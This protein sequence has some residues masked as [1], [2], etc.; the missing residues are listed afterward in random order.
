[1]EAKM[2]AHTAALEARLRVELAQAAPV[3]GAITSAVA[4]LSEA[5]C[6]LH[7]STVYFASL[8]PEDEDSGWRWRALLGGVMMVPGQ[9]MVAVGLVVGTN[10]PSC[11]SSDQCPQK[12]TFCEVGG[13]DRCLF[14]GTA[15]PLPIQ[16]DPATGGTLNRP[17]DGNGL[18]TPDFVGFNTTLVAEACGDPTGYM[19]R[20]WGDASGVRF[21]GYEF[22]PATVASW[23]ETCVSA[24][25]LAVDPVT[26][27][28]HTAAN[29][30]AMGSFDKAALVFAT[31][32]V[33][34]TVG[35]ELK[36]IKLVFLAIRHA[37]D[38]LSPRWRFA[39]TLLG[40]IRRWVFLP[41]LVLAVP[42]LVMYKGGE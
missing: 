42:V 24:I 7:Q 41:T 16:T 9:C 34:M 35:G 2:I 40:G 36:D 12:G 21:Q 26:Q 17:T 1:M 18:S 11:E 33:A 14:C 32:I 19:V 3:V 23:C 10:A 15:A 20:E 30:A 38:K 31:F 6:N 29:V 39:L 25:D 13:Q 28:S 27:I 22:T 8:P 5:P 37:G 4:H